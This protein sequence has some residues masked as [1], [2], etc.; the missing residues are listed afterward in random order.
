[1]VTIPSNAGVTVRVQIIDTTSHINGVPNSAVFEENIP[2]FDTFDG[3]CYAFLIT[4]QVPGSPPVRLIFDLGIRKDWTNWIPDSVERIKVWNAPITIE[5]NVSEILE[6]DRDLGGLEG[7]KAI[8][9]SHA[10]FDHTGDPSTFPSNV[11]LMVG[12]G[13]KEAYMPGWPTKEDAPVLESCFEGREV[14]EI[15]FEG[16]N[17]EIGGFQALDFFNDGSFYLLNAPGVSQS[18]EYLDIGTLIDISSTHWDT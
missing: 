1:M 16:T 4:H 6:G 10:H 17:L 11:D 3:V 14:K 18:P 2:G 13:M 9:W 12:P 15:S 5:K 7:V 8:I